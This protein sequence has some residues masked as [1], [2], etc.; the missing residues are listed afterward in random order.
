MAATYERC[1]GGHV[2][3]RIRPVPGTPDER[4]LAVLA[5][6]PGSDWRCVPDPVPEPVVPPELTRPAKSASK[7]DWVAWAV[8]CGA[9][10]ADAALLT[11]PQLIETYGGE[12]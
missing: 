7:A 12:G 11:I 1:A 4:R 5:A 9:D 2:A 8:R 6:D 3:E 10:P